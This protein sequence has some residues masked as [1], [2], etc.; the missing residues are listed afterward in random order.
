[1][2][3]YKDLKRTINQ[4]LKQQ[5]NI[6]INSNDISEGFKRPSFFV[7]FDDLTRS[8][9]P[10]HYEKSLTVRI[11][12]FP[13]TINESSIEIL[14]IHDE[15]EDLFDLKLQVGERHLNIFETTSTVSDGVLQFEF[16]LQFSDSKDNN[17][18]HPAMEELNYK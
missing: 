15:L 6:P 13:T 10:D 18:V 12:Y 17:E 9:S 3:T 14:E 2:I 16:D 1:M 4:N 5:F 8:S 11:Y 7:E